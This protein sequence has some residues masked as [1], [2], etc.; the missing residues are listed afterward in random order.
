MA[1][2]NSVEA[3]RPQ[4]PEERQRDVSERYTSRDSAGKRKAK[5]DRKSVV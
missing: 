2:W 4:T 1:G 3:S 5:V